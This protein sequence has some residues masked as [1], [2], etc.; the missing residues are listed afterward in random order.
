MKTSLSNTSIQS[1]YDIYNIGVATLSPT[2]LTVL[3]KLH[4]IY[5]IDNQNK[6][7]TTNPNR[8]ITI[9]NKNLNPMRYFFTC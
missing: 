2:L 4:H 8:A 3:R 6:N 1:I 9:N 5:L 7:C